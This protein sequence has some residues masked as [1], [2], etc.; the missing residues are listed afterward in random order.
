MQLSHLVVDFGNTFTKVA[1]FETSE[2]NFRLRIESSNKPAISNFFENISFCNSIIVSSV[3]NIE[4]ELENIIKSKCK[5]YYT[6][7]YKLKFPFLNKYLTPETLGNDRLAAV[8]G[9]AKKFPKSTILIIDSGTCITYDIL[10]NKQEYLGGSI[11]PGIAMRFNSL[12]YFT[13]KLPLI[14]FKNTFSLIGNST[15]NAIRS[16]VLNG[17]LYEVMGC[18]DAFSEQYKNLKI[19]LTGGD[20]NF[21]SE[22]LK[23]SSIFVE[24]NL[25]LIGLHEILIYN[26]KK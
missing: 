21:F 1:S 9:A 23:N 16:G 10:S 5:H 26:V 2:I 8:C 14:T 22:N 11:S 24:P 4:S 17:L 6:F 13:E 12:N 25:V 19:V 3:V 15:E 20:S 7:S 18:I